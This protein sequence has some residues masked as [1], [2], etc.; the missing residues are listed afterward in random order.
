MVEMRAKLQFGQDAR[1][2]LGNQAVGVALF[3]FDKKL[4]RPAV[5]KVDIVAFPQAC[6]TCPVVLLKPIS[7]SNSQLPIADMSKYSAHCTS[8]WC[9]NDI[10]K[11]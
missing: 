4:A 3:G 10:P 11:G 2:E 6:E 7:L 8:P 5:A 9:D 1:L